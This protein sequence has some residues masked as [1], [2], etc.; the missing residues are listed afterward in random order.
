MKIVFMGTPTFAVP[1]LQK[2]LEAG[3][4]VIAVYSQPDRPSG[5]GNKLTRTPVK[6]FA[7]DNEL[8]VRQPKSLRSQEVQAEL[9]SLLPEVIV[10]AAYGLF[11]PLPVLELPPLGCLNIHPSLLPKYRGPSPVV[12]AIL[13]GDNVTGVTIMK[14]D[15]GMDSGPILAQREVPIGDYETAPE[16]TERLFGVGADLLI[17]TLQAWASERIEA[18]PQ[19]DRQATITSL[20]KKE[21]GEID[22][23]SSPEH[24]TRM[25]RAYQPWP[26]TFTHWNGKLLKIFRAS[27]TDGKAP[28]G[29]IV[30]LGDDRL[31]IG[32][33]DGV[34]EVTSLQIEGK[35]AMAVSEFLLGNRDFLGAELGR[36]T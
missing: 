34:L 13:N 24:I 15:E 28:H 30:S 11:L 26:G 17:D 1:V 16:L 33:S 4:D 9:A 22:W 27:A 14:L 6:Q 3:H 32:T 25:I 19:D 12:T 21:D 31:G 10:V 2:L 20:V 36:K 35:K 29:R 7:L 8:E 5:R 18:H 23:N